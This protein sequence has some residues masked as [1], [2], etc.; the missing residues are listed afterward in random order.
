MKSWQDFSD[1]VLAIPRVVKRMIALTGDIAMCVLSVW[2][3]FYLRL[4]Y[5]P[6][7]GEG[8]IHPMM[9]SIFLALP[10]FVTFGLYRAIF[11]HSG[12]EAMVSIFRA[13]T[14]YTFPSP[15]FTR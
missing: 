3:A 1:A 13:V 2:L 5:V 6:A 12:P 11:R 10:I 7:L 8:P 9:V 14:V 15:A 4:G